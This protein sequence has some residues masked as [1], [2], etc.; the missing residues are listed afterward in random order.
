MSRIYHH[1]DLLL[2]YDTVIFDLDG[3]L[4]DSDWFYAD[5]FGE[6]AGWLVRAGYLGKPDPWVDCL[7]GLKRAR[8]NDDKRI[9]DD[10][11]VLLNINLTVK[12]KLLTLY[13]EHDCQGLV[14]DPHETAVLNEL[15][16][17]GRQLFIITN[18]RKKLQ[19]QKVCRLGLDLHME[20][21]IILDPL[22]KIRLKP[23]PASFDYLA[24]KYDLG[25]TV[26]VGD[27]FDIDGVFAQNS[28]IDFLG[29]GFYGN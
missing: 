5:V 28:G 15:K 17:R 23:D 13:R 8:G 2:T 22:G 27:R 11:L 6:M 18:G 29:V 24:G 19:E 14:L 21:V 12:E 4:F 1:K 7:M 9:I 25:R 10:G 3:T 26:M 16:T 20:E